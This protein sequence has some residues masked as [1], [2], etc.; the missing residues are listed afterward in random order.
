V[1]TNYVLRTKYRAGIQ[2]AETRHDLAERSRREFVENIL[3]TDYTLCVRG[4]GNFS[5]RFYEALAFGRIPV[6]IDTDCALPYHDLVDWPRYL[7]WVDA[8]DVDDAPRLV[9]DFHARLSNE[10]FRALQLACRQLWVDR[11]SPDGFYA[12]FHEHFAR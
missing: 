10:A 3:G 2:S 11:L 4:G 5:V 8:R 9:A 6:L 7:P 1:E 12:H